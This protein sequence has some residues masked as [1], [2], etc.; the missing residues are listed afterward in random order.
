MGDAG[1]KK[2]NGISLGC[3]LGHNK[4]T[5]RCSSKPAIEALAREIAQ[6]RLEGSQTVQERPP[7]NGI[8]E[9]AVGLVAGQARTLKAA[10]EH[11]IET[12]SP[13]DARILCWLMEFAACLM[14]RC[15]IGSESPIL[16]FG[17]KILYTPAQPARGGKWE[18]RFHPG[19]FV[20]MLNS[21]SEGVVVTEQG[22]AIKTR[23]ANVRRIPESER[24]DTD[25][26]L[27]MRVV[28]WSPD[29]SDNAFDIQVGIGR[30]AEV[31]PRSH[32]E[33]LN[34]KRSSEDVLLQ[35]RLRT[36]GPQRWLPWVPGE[37]RQQA[38]SEARRRSES[39]LRGDSS[40]SS[41]LAA[42]DER[43]IRALAD[44]VER[45]AR[46]TEEGQCR[47]SSRIGVSEENCT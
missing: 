10:L 41:R 4:V 18:P 42:A 44:A 36:M 14:K 28:P 27:R 22:L 45:H 39:L 6:A 2:R 17:E 30:H 16:E 20:G 40:G 19:M 13:P 23:A 1:S 46:H 26:K 25:R 33:V 15:G 24:W 9:R 35:R 31:V 38:H 29:G 32:G 7:S 3:K 34:G 37:G 5:L 21:S 11:R 8:I 43:K 47:L 12:G